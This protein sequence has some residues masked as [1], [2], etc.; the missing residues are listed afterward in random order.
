MRTRVI[1]YP[2]PPIPRPSLWDPYEPT[3]LRSCKVT[4]PACIV[5]A[6]TPPLPVQPCFYLTTE[7]MQL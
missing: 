2:S 5:V 4:S 3:S 7:K 1:A 6:I